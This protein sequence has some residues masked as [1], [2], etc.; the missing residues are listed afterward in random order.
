MAPSLYS[1]KDRA[2]WTF[3]DAKSVALKSRYVEAYHLDG[4]MCWEISGDD[5]SGTLINAMYSREMPDA[6]AN[7]LHY[8]VGP[9]HVRLYLTSSH[10][11]L[12]EGSNVILNTE[13]AARKAP[14]VKVEF[15]V[16]GKSIGYDTEAP[17]DWVW[18][19]AQRGK[20][21]IKVVAMDSEDNKQ[22]SN[23]VNVVIKDIVR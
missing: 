6:S 21:R 18:F 15:F 17:F 9:P 22:T 4:I 2:F 1:K 11:Q 10:D 7:R 12:I 23:V 19:N 14:V 3:D 20:H 16:D 5:S 13:V 8:R